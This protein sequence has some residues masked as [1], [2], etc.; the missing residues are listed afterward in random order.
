MSRILEGK[1]WRRG[2]VEPRIPIPLA[3]FL[4]FVLA[5]LEEMFNIERYSPNTAILAAFEIVQMNW[6]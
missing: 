6:S 4:I 5:R 1:R 2:L 3:P